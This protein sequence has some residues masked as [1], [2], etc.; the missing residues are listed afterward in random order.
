[1]YEGKREEEQVVTGVEASVIMKMISF[2]QYT[3]EY[4]IFIDNFF[5]SFE[6]LLK[7][8]ERN[9]MATGTARYNRMIKCSLKSDNI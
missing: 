8:K 5:I 7:L 2:L 3:L 9:V 1:I 6:L 4:E